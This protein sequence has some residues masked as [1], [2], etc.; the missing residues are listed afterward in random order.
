MALKA[1]ETVDM[2]DE[3]RNDTVKIVKYF[4]TSVLD[5]SEEFHKSLGRKNY[6]TPTS[7][8]ELI[9]SFRTLLNSKQE[10]TM[11]AKKRQVTRLS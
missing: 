9:N 3:M 4:H 2:E 8:L 6:V 1:L 11:K 10:G 7:Y 5:L